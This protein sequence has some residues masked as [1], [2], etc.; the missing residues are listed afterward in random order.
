VLDETDLIPLCNDETTRLCRDP[1]S[2]QFWVY[3]PTA[4]RS[5]PRARTAEGAWKKWY[6][7]LASMTP[8]K[9]L[10]AVF[11]SAARSIKEQVPMDILMKVT[12]PDK[13]VV[14]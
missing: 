11:L 13:E 8:D 4:G 1:A 2:E 6:E 3:A 10:Q 7:T 5:F 14:A 9:K 12:E